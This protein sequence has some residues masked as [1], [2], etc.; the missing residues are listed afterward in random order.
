MKKNRKLLFIFIIN[1]LIILFYNNIIIASNNTE[2]FDLNETK[3][4]KIENMIKDIMKKSKI[5]AIS[6]VII[7]EKETKYFNYGYFNSTNDIIVNEETLF[8]L[9]SLSKSY[10]ALA[11]FLLQEQGKLSLDDPITKYIPWLKMK[12]N[13]DY[14]GSYINSY[15][16]LKISNFLYQSSGI[17]FQTIGYIPEG[18]SD[19]MLE[20][21][22]RTLENINLDFYPGSK[23]QYATLNYDVLALVIENITGQTYEEFITENILVPLNLNNT[24]TYKSKDVLDKLIPGYKMNFF[25]AIPYDA[26]IY[27]GNTAAGYIMSSAKDMGQW[28]RIQLGLVEVPLEYKEIISKTHQGDT[29]VASQGDY[30]YAGGWQVHIR[31]ENIFHGGS[32]P[33]YSSMLIMKPQENLGVCVLTNMN[34]GAAD[35]I[36]Q[37]IINIL[38]GKKIEKYNNDI[39]KNLDAIF[40]IVTIGAFIFI[41]LF[42]ILLIKALIELFKQKRVREKL[43][44]VKIAGL[45]LAIPLM[46]FLGFCIYYLPNIIMQR[47]PWKA[48]NVWGSKSVLFGCISAY[49]ACVIFMIYVIFT[50]N[51]PQENEK[52]YF[53]LIPLNIVNGLSSAL[54]I[55]TINESFNRELKYSKELLVYFVFSLLF[56]VYSM[57]LVQGKMIVI[58]NQYA[59]KKR[60]NII[61]KVLCSSYQTIERIGQEKIFSSLNNDTS[62]VS[63]IP[64]TIVRFISDILT[65]IFCL[66]YLLSKNIY[67]FFVSVGIIILNGGISFI[68]SRRASKYWEKNRDVQ[69]T[70]FGQMTDL[71]YGFKE[72][73][74][75]KF[76]RLAFWKDMQKFSKLSASLN[77][78]ASIK[79]LNYDMYNTLMYNLV[80]GVVVFIFPLLLPGISVN[81]LRENLFIV[82]YMIGPFSGITYAVSQ[83]TQLKVSMKRIDNLIKELDENSD[84]QDINI[85]TSDSNFLQNITLELKDITYQYTAKD[86]EEEF[87]LGPITAE[88]KT[89]Q[90]TF[91]VG[92]NGSGKSTLGKILTGLY[93]P[94]EGIRKINGKEVQNAQINKCFSAIYSDFYL[95]KK[96]YGIDYEKKKEEL[97][98]YL[99]IMQ[100]KEKI[101]INNEGEF[102]NFNLSTGQKKRLALVICHLEDKPMLLF[103]EWAAEQDPEFRHYFYMEILPKLKEQG[104]G[105][106]VI[107]HD[108]RYFESADKIIKL[109]YGKMVEK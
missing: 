73:I 90:I 38:E 61:N 85:D 48:V 4:I 44:D 103:D 21:T 56:F 14:E 51:F 43:S 33:N 64:G 22:V 91:I 10:T 19:N 65:L 18:N 63:Q 27:R 24:Y 6:A 82:F 72:L 58:T 100:I 60:I 71:I 30:Y 95:F 54:I 45:L 93:K 62:T 9:G 89:G 59:Y 2:S 83:L 69:D 53:T 1:I 26:P 25:Q 17:P 16:D 92:G 8:E 28:M 36:A 78:S 47:L 94:T 12:F 42:L 11:I 87:T 37:N 97:N 41:I 32:N 34:S 99:D 109:E 35:Y 7:N 20:Y 67:A 52:N 80:F 57:K 77:K 23:H 105:I 75:N 76:R 98:Q 40:S 96:L 88:F 55:F 39:Y 13:G 46:I 102:K 108:D 5:P 68:T 70:Y 106:I 101:L 15:V 107:T 29:S 86:Q 66:L 31:K 84:E 79:F 50:F 104:K 74:L 49:I 3:Q 81:D